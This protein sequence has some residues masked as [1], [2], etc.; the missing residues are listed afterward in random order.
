[1][2]EVATFDRH[3]KRSCS[4]MA[5]NQ[6]QHVRQPRRTGKR[7]IALCHCSGA[8]L[9]LH[10]VAA[11]HSPLHKVVRR[12]CVCVN[13]KALASAAERGCAV[14][15]VRVVAASAV[16]LYMSGRGGGGRGVELTHLMH[17]LVAADAVFD[18][19]VRSSSVGRGHIRCRIAGNKHGCRY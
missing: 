10:C 16:C 3:A 7:G 9:C 15:G 5:L 13:R 14:V 2:L 8:V 18:G 12:M 4:S 17:P 6:S 1:M 19:F 11:A